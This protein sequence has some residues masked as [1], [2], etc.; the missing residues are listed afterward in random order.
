VTMIMFPDW[1]PADPMPAIARPI[2]KVVEPGATPQRREPSSKMPTATRYIVL[3]EKKVYSR[4]KMS[5]KAQLV[6]K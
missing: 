1:I 6:I 2:M 5:C 4:P 3:D